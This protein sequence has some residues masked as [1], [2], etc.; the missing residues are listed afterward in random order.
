VTEPLN[1]VQSFSY[2]SRGW[3]LSQTDPNGNTTGFQYDGNGNLLTK[4]DPSPGG[5]TSYAYD[6]EDQLIQITDPLLH[7]VTLA[8]D[9]AGRITGMT[10]ALSTVRFQLDGLGH[11]IKAFDAD[12]RQVTLNWYDSRELLEEST[13]GVGRVNDWDYDSRGSMIQFT[14][15]LGNGTTFGYDAVGRLTQATSPLA[16]VTTQGYDQ[17]GN[18]GSLTNALSNTTAFSFDLGERLSAVTTASNLTT[19][20][21]C[22]S[23]NLVQTVTKPSGQV[24]TNTYDPAWRLSQVVDGYATT[25]YQ[26]DN[27]GHLVETDDNAG[28]TSRQTMRT[29]DALGRL[30][31]YTDELLIRNGSCLL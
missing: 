2:T 22:N 21:T 10:D 16:N 12:S 14:D 18:R 13:D 20:Y 19:V 29:Y 26:Y 3:K 31:A 4:I 6:G 28:G 17:D 1:D 8:R 30:V 7:T 11:I 5:T 23:R 15:G 27:A 25:G 24:A 9:N